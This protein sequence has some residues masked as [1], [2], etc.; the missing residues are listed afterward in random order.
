MDDCEPTKHSVNQVSD[1]ALER[2]RRIE[3]LSLEIEALKTAA[4]R[5]SFP[6]WIELIKACSTPIAFMGVVTAFIV[7]WTQIRQAQDLQVRLRVDGLIRLLSSEKREERLSAISSLSLFLTPDNRPYHRDTLRALSAAVAVEREALVESSLYGTFESV[8][9]GVV[10][11][12]D[13]SATLNVLLKLN[14]TVNWDLAV[15]EEEERARNDDRQK[16]TLH[17][18]N[19]SPRWV[20]RSYLS[21]RSA[22]DLRRLATLS[23]VA[24]L[25]VRKGAKAT[26]FSNI[27][28]RECDFSRLTLDGADFSGAF[29]R[30]SDFTASS[31]R[32]TTFLSADLTGVRF[33]K[34]ILTDSILSQGLFDRWASWFKDTSRYNTIYSPPFF[35]CS[36]LRGADLT[37]RV[38][39]AVNIDFTGASNE[40]STSHPEI[41]V[42]PFN[43]VRVDKNT[44][45]DPLG[46]VWTVQMPYSSTAKEGSSRL[47]ESDPLFASQASY[48]SFPQQQSSWSK[49]MITFRRFG[50]LRALGRSVDMK[51]PDRALLTYAFSQGKWRDTLLPDFLS[52]AILQ[53]NDPHYRFSDSFKRGACEDSIPAIDKTAGRATIEPFS[54]SY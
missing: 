25:L 3:K 17:N 15:R 42:T 10:T 43:H 5:F 18:P 14:R 38:I 40:K 46:V 33:Y 6:W 19:L 9:E 8:Q 30:G 29:L 21:S 44:K 13:S 49:P 52:K 1:D 51:A 27:Y 37:F 16:L 36:D 35:E 23:E 45:I 20:E 41:F 24:M 34:A 26:N 28:C 39:A 22:E 48:D 32:K 47:E 12:E 31:L 53:Q 50:G 2:L 54:D 7:G 11:A 4:R